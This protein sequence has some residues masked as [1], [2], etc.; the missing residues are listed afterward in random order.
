LGVIFDE[1]LAQSKIP[2]KDLIDVWRDFIKSGNPR[3]DS[4]D[5][6]VGKFHFSI[7]PALG[8]TLSTGWA[9]ILAANVGFY[10]S[11]PD[12]TNLS[13]ITTNMVYSQYNQLTV[14]ILANIWTKNNKYNLVADWRY[15]K[16]PQDTYGLGEH[17]ALRDAELI[18]YSHLR[19]HQSILKKIVPGFYVGPG[20]FLDYHWNINQSGV[21]DSILSDAEKY[22]LPA[23]SISSGPGINLLYDNRSNSIN[24]QGGLYA[25]ALYRANLHF[26]GS[27]NNW[28]SLTIDIRKY[29]KFPA[30]SNNI[31]AFWNYDWLTLSGKPPYLDLP[32]TGWDAY[33]NT[34]RGYIQ[35][36]FRGKNMLYLESEYRFQ[37]TRN[38][39]FGGVVFVNGQGFSNYPSDSKD[40]DV[41]WPGF[42]AGI[43]IKVNKHSN[44]NIAIDYGFGSDGSHGLFVNLGEVF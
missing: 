21:S 3:V 41:I 14:P 6:A 33:N 40:Y 25:N 30:G 2:K 27:D 17:S 12:K 37:L 44:T 34:G 20:Y 24:P 15:Y 38:G 35:G 36:R 32:S 10:V 26:M 11:D 22:G 16:Y 28:Q 31:L 29:I 7:V 39:L 5:K 4:T 13:S 43:R 8:Y 18:D 9:G 1:T 23:K 19:V 42:G